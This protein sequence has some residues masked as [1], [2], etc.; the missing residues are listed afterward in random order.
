VLPMP[1]LSQPGWR[2]LLFLLILISLSLA[3]C[4]RQ[5]VFAPTPEPEAA[6]PAAPKPQPTL[7]YVAVSRLNLRA[8]PGMDCPRISFLERNQV[9]EKLGESEDWYQV[10]VRPT[11]TIG[12]V[13][14][15]YL[16]V[17]PVPEPPPMEIVSP[18]ST[19][20]Q[21]VTSKPGEV[22]P[23]VK[24]PEAP[25]VTEPS[26]PQV[27]KPAAPTEKP[28]GEPPVTVSPTA[29]PAAAEVKSTPE[30]ATVPEATTTP[31]TPPAPE[32][33]TEPTPESG[34]KRIR[35]M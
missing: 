2:G 7:Y 8:C 18:P 31:S 17:S 1:V 30:P 25:E 10:R 34:P 5:V 33:P 22:I 32:P 23:R 4:Y 15:R 21:P 19:P 24:K 3:G 12:W 28:A 14:S 16:S 20:E 35:I 11:D 6:V 26:T 9:V 29:T 13:S 27:K